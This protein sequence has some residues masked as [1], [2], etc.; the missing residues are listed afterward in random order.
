MAA[1]DKTSKTAR[2]MSLLSKKPDPAAPAEESAPAPVCYTHLTRPTT[3]Y[4]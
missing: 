1:K 2:V 4:V 3:P